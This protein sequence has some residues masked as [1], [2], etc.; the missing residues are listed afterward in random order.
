M[1][2][3][4]VFANAPAMSTGVSER[5]FN[6]GLCLPSGSNLTSEDLSRVVEHIRKKLEMNQV[7]IDLIAG[8]RPNFMKIAPIIRALQ[9]AEKN[10]K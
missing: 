6:T 1:H 10:G 8:A 2:L 5:L 7:N 3:Q 9:E 4:P